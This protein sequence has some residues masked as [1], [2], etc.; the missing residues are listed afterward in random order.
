MPQQIEFCKTCAVFNMYDNF[1]MPFVE[2]AYSY[3]GVSVV[4][5]AY[6]FALALGILI[7]SARIAMPQNQNEWPLADIIPRIIAIIIVSSLLQSGGWALPMYEAVMEWSTQVALGLIDIGAGGHAR[8]PETAK[9]DAARLVGTAELYLWDFVAFSW[10]ILEAPGLFESFWN[11]V[12]IW[13]VAGV[14]GI[15]TFVVYG[16]LVLY[17]MFIIGR[18]VLF[19]Q[20]AVAFA[21]LI[22]AAYPFPQTRPTFVAGLKMIINAWLTIIFA[23]FA[24]GITSS[25][26]AGTQEMIGCFVRETRGNSCV[27][28]TQKLADAMGVSNDIFRDSLSSFEVFAT[29]IILG[30]F[31]WMVHWAAVR[32][33]STLTQSPDDSGPLA[34]FAGAATGMVSMGAHQATK[35][36]PMSIKAGMTA[37]KVGSYGGR[38]GRAGAVKAGRYGAKLAVKSRPYIEQGAKS[39]YELSKKFARAE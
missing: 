17:F 4:A 18:S 39:V 35:S 28:E 24:M 37:G 10:K 7:Y 8:I 19:I 23:G 12:S 32:A 20:I 22:V 14:F 27:Q 3:I 5:L 38:L 9:T 30:V 25:I 34:A 11:G 31:C 36:L 33:A 16:G 29:L 1:S 2:A 26:L 21:P 15:L 6:S 13:L